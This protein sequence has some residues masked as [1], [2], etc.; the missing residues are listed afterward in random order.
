MLRIL[1]PGLVPLAVAMAL[2]PPLGI[3]WQSTPLFP[4]LGKIRFTAQILQPQPRPL[5]TAMALY[6]PLAAPRGSLPPFFPFC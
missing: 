2:Y 5:A 1:Q 6:P 4:P 3:P